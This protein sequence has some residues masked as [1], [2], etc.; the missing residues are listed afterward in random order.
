MAQSSSHKS[1]VCGLFEACFTL[2]T[3][4]TVTYGTDVETFT[5]K[6]GQTDTLA[7]LEPSD[8]LPVLIRATNGDSKDKL[9]SKV[10][11]STVVQPSDMETFYTRYAEVCRAGMSALKKRDRKA[12]KNK[13][14]KRKGAAADGKKPVR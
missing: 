10:K 14:K 13:A 12:H 7:D 9:K 1:D 2:L 3:V 4:A 8:P 6:K 11:I 5:A